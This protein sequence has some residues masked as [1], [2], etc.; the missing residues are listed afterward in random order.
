MA[1]L[2]E[3]IEGNSIDSQEAQFATGVGMSRQQVASSSSKTA[4]W[5]SLSTASQVVIEVKE[6]KY[7]D[8]V[9]KPVYAEMQDA[10]DT[11]W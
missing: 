5:L 11:A 9:V 4:V 2:E 6:N 1:V 7:V 8:Q 10:E 3:L